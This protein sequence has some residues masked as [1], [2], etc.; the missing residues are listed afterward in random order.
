[1]NQEFRASPEIHSP[2]LRLVELWLRRERDERIA[3]M[4]VLKEREER[5]AEEA[6]KA[7]DGSSRMHSKIA[8]GFTAGRLAYKQAVDDW[9]E[10]KAERRAAAVAAAAAEQQ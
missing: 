3:R 7:K 4:G 2:L 10:A 5:L 8:S 6:D 1:M 9:E